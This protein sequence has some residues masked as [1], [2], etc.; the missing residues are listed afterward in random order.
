MKKKKD[1]LFVLLLKIAANMRQC[2]DEF[3]D[4][5]IHENGDNLRDFSDRIKE[6]ETNGD[7][8]VHE[9]IVE[10]NKAFITPIE[11]EDILALAEQMDEVVDG[12]EECAIYTDMFGLSKPDK[13]IDGFKKNLAAGCKELETAVQL[14]TDKKLTQIREHTVNVKT[15]EEECDHIE[16]KSIRGL[17]ELYRDDP[18]KIM[19]LKD[20]YR[21]LENTVDQSQTVAKALD[22]IVMKNM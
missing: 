7:T 14:L 18:L 8:L 17:F 2:A 11:H 16:R 20:I 4:F 12:M 19:E 22:M 21:M 5:D 13:Y 10:L 3:R 15:Y 1:K 9:T 6:L